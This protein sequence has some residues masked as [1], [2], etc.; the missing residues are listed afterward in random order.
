MQYFNFCACN[1]LIFVRERIYGVEEN[2]Y[3]NRYAYRHKHTTMI[4]NLE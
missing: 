4:H 3:V 2:H 1:Y